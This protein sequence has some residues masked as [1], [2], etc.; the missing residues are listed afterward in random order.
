MELPFPEMGAPGRGV[1]V[2]RRA[3]AQLW[4]RGFMRKQGSCTDPTRA[5]GGQGLVGRRS[6]LQLNSLRK[7][8]K[9]SGVR[10]FCVQK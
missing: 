1:G 2:W 3:A 4:G 7:S 10:E 9:G 5:E 8:C 6:G